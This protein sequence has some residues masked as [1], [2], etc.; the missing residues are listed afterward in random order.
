MIKS[1]AIDP[2]VVDADGVY[3]KTGPARVFTRG[4]G[5]D[6]GDQRMARSIKAGDVIVLICRGPMGSGMEEIYQMTVGAEVSGLWASMW[7]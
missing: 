3:R 1:T 6:R 2:T 5:G 7:R 4:E